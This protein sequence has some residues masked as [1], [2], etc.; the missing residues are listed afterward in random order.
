MPFIVKL[1]NIEIF[2]ILPPLK[3]VYCALKAARLLS[4]VVKVGWGLE[5]LHYKVP[6]FAC[7]ESTIV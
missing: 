3:K 1:D 4:W 2:K 5:Y 7:G 6:E